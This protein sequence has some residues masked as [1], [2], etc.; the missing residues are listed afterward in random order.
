MGD[1]ADEFLRRLERGED[2]DIEEFAARY[3]ESAA[4][5]RQVLNALALVRSPN[6]SADTVADCTPGNFGDSDLEIVS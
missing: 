3:P 5:I 2:P 4:T 1:L 6:A